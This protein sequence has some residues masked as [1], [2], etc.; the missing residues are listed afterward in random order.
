MIVYSGNGLVNNLINK[1]SFELHV[2]GGYQYC[3]PGTKLSKRLSRGD[4]GINQLDSF[5]KEY[6]I[7]HSKSKD[8]KERNIADK[9]LAK[10]AE[11]RIYSKDAN[12]GEKAAALAV[13]HIMKVIFNL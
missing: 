4:Q 9:I 8:I 13:S 5:C 11:D 12:I 3:G 6:D 1:L 10:K 7:I 2:P